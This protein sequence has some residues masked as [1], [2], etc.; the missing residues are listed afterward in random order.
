MGTL[1]RLGIMRKAFI[2]TGC[3]M[4]S[5]VLVANSMALSYLD[6]KLSGTRSIQGASGWTMFVT[7]VTLIMLPLLLT[8][9][10]GVQR[11]VNRTGVELIILAV[12]SLFWFISGIALAAKSGEYSCLSRRLC[13]RVRAATAF[14]WLTF[15][16]LLAAMAVVGLI[17]R[18]QVKL[19]LPVFAAYSFDVEGDEVAD[20][21]QRR[22]MQSASVPAAPFGRGLSAVEKQ[23]MDNSHHAR[24]Y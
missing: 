15:F 5:A 21:Q 17:A 2:A 20:Q 23:A 24:A 16:V 10:A 7:I 4:V 12:L 22:A 19:G 18:V 6:N 3:I 11:V 1:Y 13:H 8:R 9:W 14:S